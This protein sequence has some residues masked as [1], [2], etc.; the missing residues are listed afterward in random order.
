MVVP[1]SLSGYVK[2]LFHCATC[3]WQLLSAGDGGSPQRRPDGNTRRRVH[4]AGGGGN[5]RVR[6]RSPGDKST[7]GTMCH[8]MQPW[9]ETL[10]AAGEAG[11]FSGCCWGS[12]PVKLPASSASFMS[13]RCCS[14]F[15]VSSSFLLYTAC[16]LQSWGKHALRH[17]LQ[18][19]LNWR[20]VGLEFALLLHLRLCVGLGLL[21][22]SSISSSFCKTETKPKKPQQSNL[23]LWKILH[24]V[25]L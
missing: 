9:C 2:S 19:Q 15:Y 6:L 21:G 24:S 1:G 14:S 22:A 10:K 13:Y 17:L 18:P 7:L 12:L 11:F 8:S 4:T 3:R 16:E 25:L 20:W 23:N 5:N